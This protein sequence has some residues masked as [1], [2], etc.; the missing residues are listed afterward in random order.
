[1]PLYAICP[2]F[3]YEKG[4]II[5]CELKPKYF[6]NQEQKK[7]WLSDYC[8]SFDYQYCAHARKLFIK[9]NMQEILKKNR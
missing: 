5:A 4:K 1:M 3:L 7:N 8:C 2:F 9:Y 6:P